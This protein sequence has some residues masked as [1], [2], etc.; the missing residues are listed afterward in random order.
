MGSNLKINRKDLAQ[1]CVQFI[2][3]VRDVLDLINGKWKLP[4]LIALSFGNKRFNELERDVIGITPRM[5]SKELRDLE[6]N[7]LIR[8]T[9][10]DTVPVT[11]EYSLT[12]Y[13]RSLDNVIAALRDWGKKHRNRLFKKD[14]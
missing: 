7:E 11:V 3:P 5:L 12:D 8:R 4:I 13:G 9:V 2:R 6:A 14:K 10:Y 1:E